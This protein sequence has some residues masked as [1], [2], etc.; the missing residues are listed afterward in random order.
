MIKNFT[1][2]LLLCALTLTSCSQGADEPAGEAN[3]LPGESSSVTM[4]ISRAAADD[5][6]AAGISEITIFTYK[7][8]RKGTEFFSEKTVDVTSG[9]D[10]TLEFPLGESY[11]TFAVANASDITGKETFETVTLHMNPLQLDDVW[12]SAPVTFSSDKSESRVLLTL[13]RA[14]SRINFVP[15]EDDAT[16]AAITDF[17]RLDVTFRNVGSAY[18]V[19][20]SSVVPEDIT[21]STLQANGFKNTFHTFETAGAG[22]NALLGLS[23]YKGG[24]IVFESPS[25]LEAGTTFTASRSYNVIVQVTNTEYQSTPQAR[26]ASPVITVEENDFNF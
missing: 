2:L 17:D 16:L 20:T 11:R 21:I 1:K 22:L 18:V 26:G 3:N 13:R 6:Q 9:S 24:N 25:D 5:F 15:N 14:V 23:Y 12:M 19:S 10:F 4:T 8:L 7:V